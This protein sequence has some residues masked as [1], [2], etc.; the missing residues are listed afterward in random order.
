[1]MAINDFWSNSR[2]ATEYE[3]NTNIRKIMKEN[4]SPTIEKREQA[5]RRVFVEVG[6][7]AIPLPFLGEKEFGEN[8]AYIGLDINKEEVKSAKQS[9]E[10]LEA[11]NERPKINKKLFVAA[12]MGHLPLPD[13]AVD[14]LFLGNVLGD[15]SILKE[16]H[17]KLFEEIKRVLT[18]D[19]ELII[20]ENNTPLPK[21]DLSDFLFRH[22]FKISR[23]ITPRDA[24]W[25]KEMKQYH[26]YDAQHPHWSAY[27]VYAKK[28]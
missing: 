1:M 21:D 5:K 26:K 3:F 22:N 27:I 13:N 25:V 12:D 16:D 19:G 15:P 10:M 14:Q 11:Y 28:I 23:F 8:D 2:L 18:K 20:K 4:L 24:E 17:N 6:T 7:N 9:A